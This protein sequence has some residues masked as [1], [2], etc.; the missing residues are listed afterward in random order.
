LSPKVL[1]ATETV[2]WY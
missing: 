1:I 2:N